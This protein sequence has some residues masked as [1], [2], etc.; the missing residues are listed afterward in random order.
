MLVHLRI[1]FYKKLEYSDNPL[2]YKEVQ[3]VNSIIVEQSKPT[4][5]L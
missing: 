4:L 3:A 1:S 5:D 2:T